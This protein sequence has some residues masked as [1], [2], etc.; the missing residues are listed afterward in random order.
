MP[1][2]EN[3]NFKSQINW[4]ITDEHQQAFQIVVIVSDRIAWQMTFRTIH[5]NILLSFTYSKL[6]KTSVVNYQKCITDTVCEFFI[7]FVTQCRCMNF[8]GEAVDQTSQAIITK[9][10]NKYWNASKDS[11]DMKNLSHKKCFH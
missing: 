2:I 5:S 1:A 3:L 10:Q 4:R 11:L 6:L 9:I 7:H 8:F